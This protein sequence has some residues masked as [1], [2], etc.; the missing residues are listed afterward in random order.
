MELIGLLYIPAIVPCGTHSGF[1]DK[2]TMRIAVYM[3]RYM[4]TYTEYVT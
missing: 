4:H 1:H 3:V 2:A